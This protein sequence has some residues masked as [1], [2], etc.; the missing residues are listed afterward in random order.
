[1]KEKST[2]LFSSE[3]EPLSLVSSPPARVPVAEKPLYPVDNF[4]ITVK[5]QFNHRNV[6]IYSEVKWKFTIDVESSTIEIM[7]AFIIDE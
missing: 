6:E 4:K 2:S 3:S 1:M 7:D 5:D